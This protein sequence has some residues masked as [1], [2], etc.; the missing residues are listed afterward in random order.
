MICYTVAH[1]VR[2]SDESIVAIHEGERTQTLR[3]GEQSILRA[4]ES[5]EEP[6]LVRP[7]GQ[8]SLAQRQQE[9]EHGLHSC[10]EGASY[11]EYSQ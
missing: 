1:P 8:D 2:V 6:R 4:F 9:E 5:R 7:E 11:L 10:D 3:T